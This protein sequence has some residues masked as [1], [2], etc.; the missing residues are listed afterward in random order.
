M[1]HKYIGLIWFDDEYANLFPKA[2][3]VILRIGYKIIVK[4][5]TINA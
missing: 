1:L 4:M 3:S 2:I 5:L